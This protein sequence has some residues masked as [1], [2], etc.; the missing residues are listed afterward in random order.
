MTSLD[1]TFAVNNLCVPKDTAKVIQFIGDGLVK[2][3]PGEWDL[4]EYLVIGGMV[5][6]QSRANV[7]DKI[8]TIQFRFWF[9]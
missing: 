6:S 7:A 5:Y 4:S 3:E 2:V 9:N 1:A 8:Q